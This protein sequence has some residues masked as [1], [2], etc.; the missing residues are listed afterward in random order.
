M[1]QKVIEE[2]LRDIEQDAEILRWAE[3]ELFED[4]EEEESEE[5]EVVEEKEEEHEGDD[6][7]LSINPPVDWTMLLTKAEKWWWRE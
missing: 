1:L 5:E 4:M 3:P 2:E 7:K 6:V